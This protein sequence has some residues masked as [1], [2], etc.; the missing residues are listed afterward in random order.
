MF[1]YS[2]YLCLFVVQD[3]N[4]TD[5]IEQTNEFT[6]FAPTDAAINDYLKKMAATALV[7]GV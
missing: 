5:E 2:K 3:Y 1:L 4:I 7:R 6:V